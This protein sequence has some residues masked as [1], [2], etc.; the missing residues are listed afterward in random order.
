MDIYEFAS[1]IDEK[2]KILSKFK[3]RNKEW[4]YHCLQRKFT[5]S[6]EMVILLNC[7]MNHKV[8]SETA[9]W[10]VRLARYNIRGINLHMRE[11]HWCGTNYFNGTTGNNGYIIQKANFYDRYIEFIIGYFY[12]NNYMEKARI[13]IKQNK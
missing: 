11:A 1:I 2:K 4:K 13:K 6:I 12:I 7:N 10:F 3:R 8:R 9:V 5:M